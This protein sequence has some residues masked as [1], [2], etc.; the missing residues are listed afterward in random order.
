MQTSEGTIVMIYFR[1][2]LMKTEDQ[3][4]S[5]GCNNCGPDMSGSLAN[6]QKHTTQNFFGFV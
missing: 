5:D 2:D 4:L 6:V 3:F 1:A